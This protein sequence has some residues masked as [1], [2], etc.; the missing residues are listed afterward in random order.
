MIGGGSNRG[1]LT[2]TK[3]DAD[4]NNIKLDGAE[5]V[6]STD[7]KKTTSNLNGQTVWKT[8]N[9]GIAEI[10]DLKPDTTYYI[11]ESKAPE[12]YNLSDQG[13]KEDGLGVYIGRLYVIPEG[14]TASW[15]VTNK[16]KPPEPRGSLTIIK[17]DADSKDKNGD[18]TKK[19]S[20]AEFVISTNR[21]TKASNL[22]GNTMWTTKSDGSTTISDLKA[23]TTYYIYEKTAPS[24][25]DLSSQGSIIDGLGVYIGSL[26]VKPE[27]G[28]ATWTVTNKKS[29]KIKI[30]K[31]DQE[32]NPV[33]GISFDLIEGEY[34]GDGGRYT[35]VAGDRIYVGLDNKLKTGTTDSN[36]ELVFDNLAFGTYT[37]RETW[38][39][40]ESFKR[41]IGQTV[42]RTVTSSNPNYYYNNP[43]TIKNIYFGGLTLDA[44]VDKYTGQPLSGVGFRLYQGEVSKYRLGETDTNGKTSSSSSFGGNSSITLRNRYGIEVDTMY[45]IEP[46]E[47]DLY[48]YKNPNEGYNIR[49]QGQ[50]YVKG[51]GAYIGKVTIAP[52]Q[53]TDITNLTY[54]YKNENTG[55]N[56]T[57]KYNINE[58]FGSIY[59]HKYV[60]EL[61]SDNIVIRKPLIGAKFKL[62]KDNKDKDI[63]EVL[64][65][66][67]TDTN[68]TG[69]FT[70]EGVYDENNNL[71][72]AK[73]TIERIPAGEYYV[74]EVPSFDKNGNE[75][76][77]LTIQ[78][79]Y[80]PEKNKVKI[81]K[82][83]IY[84]DGQ[85]E[86]VL[87]NDVYKVL[88][89]NEEGKEVVKK[90]YSKIMGTDNVE[91]SYRGYHIVEMKQGAETKV[92]LY[93]TNRRYIQVSG[94]VWEDI[95]DDTKNPG[96]G[97][98]KYKDNK[99][100]NDLKI[101][102]VKVKLYKKGNNSELE[103][104]KT[105]TNGNYKFSKLIPSIDLKKGIYYVEFDYSQYSK[106]AR[107]E[108]EYLYQ[109]KY[110]YKPVV[111]IIDKINGS[112]ALTQDVLPKEDA[113]II[114]TSEN[115]SGLYKAYTGYRR[116]Y[117]RGRTAN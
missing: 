12:G 82:V 7:Q 11:Y 59:L 1:K 45:T 88:E 67:I 102:G 93:I 75:L 48:E 65:K 50:Y 6:I 15:T 101:Q 34:T 46:G 108:S 68:Y 103:N 63:E 97:N 28:T 8:K 29:G 23:D 64:L 22:N 56:E 112:K 47:Y 90:K 41:N 100:E 73:V 36:G 10:S 14:G 3:I 83:T 111:P 115:M 91:H 57:V 92:G 98:N 33:S 81:A 26:Y 96:N 79:G 117:I 37:I 5:F 89:V 2:I 61:N 39:T 30:K 66:N 16:K 77:D 25:Y 95:S 105:D 86:V 21:K 109:G 32:G 72:D 40:Q 106:V 27:G 87:V 114:P 51:K 94:Y 24:G 69:E 52:G 38:S 18:Y 13:K 49:Y 78:P 80:D 58:K 9:G 55:E 19:L 53:I 99:S 62:Y 110:L 4:N 85:A 76:V 44:K 107:N 74:Y 31:V 104:I 42:K 116:R 43:I 54:T 35:G 17:V 60:E 20:G 71:I 84:Q 70:S 113:Q